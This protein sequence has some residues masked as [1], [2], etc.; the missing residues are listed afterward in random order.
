METVQGKEL[1]K[2]FKDEGVFD[3][4]EVKVK[5]EPIED[6]DALSADS[7]NSDTGDSLCSCL[8]FFI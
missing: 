3:D 6:L 5:Y 7:S 2:M 4:D 8:V 1:E